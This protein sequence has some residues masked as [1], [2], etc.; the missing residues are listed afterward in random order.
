MFRITIS[1]ETV[2][3]LKQ[4]LREAYIRGDLRAVRRLSVLV[5]IGERIGLAIILAVW[6]V[7]QQTVYTWL[8]EFVMKRWDGL[9]YRK[10]PG[11]PARLTKTQGRKRAATRPVVGRVC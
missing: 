1:K 3:R 2:K 8:N 11:R 9:V 5:M 6:N 4:E 10:A 7:S